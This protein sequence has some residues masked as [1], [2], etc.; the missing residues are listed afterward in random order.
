MYAPARGMM[1]CPRCQQPI[2][3]DERLCGSCGLSLAT[4]N[5]PTERL[6][7]IETKYETVASDPLIGRVLD[8]KYELIAPLGAG[9]MGTV[10]RARRVH[11][12]DE[13]AVKGLLPQYLSSE[14]AVERFRR[15]ARAAAL[16]RHANVVTIHD[17]GEPHGPDAPAY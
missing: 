2:T 12:G 10:Y 1:N 7:T 3:A 16:L 13:V 14:Q 5:A 4:F 6:P 8:S 17:F 11:I 9:G 15:E